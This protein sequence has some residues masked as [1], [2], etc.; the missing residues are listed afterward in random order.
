MT[1]VLVTAIGVTVVVLLATGRPRLLSIA[2]VLGVIA[3]GSTMYQVNP[4]QAGLLPLRDSKAADQVLALAGDR[5]PESGLWAV[6]TPALSAL[7]A[8]NGVPALSG[9]QWSRPSAQWRLLDP[10][11]STRV[12]GIGGVE[13]GLR[14]DAGG[15]D[16]GDRH[17]RVPT[18]SRSADPCAPALDAFDVRWV[19]SLQPLEARA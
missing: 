15:G 8:Q 2:L 12:R 11:G 4:L 19:V 10:T 3:A 16:A 7:L 6:D 13:G 1:I 17:R 14:L 9:E 18:A 5:R